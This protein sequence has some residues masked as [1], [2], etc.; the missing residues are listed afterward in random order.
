MRIGIDLDGV[1]FDTERAFRVHAELYDLLTL[2]TNNMK[3]RKSLRLQNRYNWNSQELEEF[4][5]I[6]H[7][8]IVREANYMSGVKEVLKMLKEEGHTLIVI[9]ARGGWNKIMIDITK[10]RMEEDGIIDFIDKFYF[11]TENKDEVCIKENIDLMIDDSVS[12]CKMVS[13]NK[14]KT[15]Y[16]QAEGLYEMEDNEYL[17]TLYNWGEVYRYIKEMER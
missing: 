14:I 17:T 12:K 10:E 4:L 6:Y 5:Q 13:E 3:D 2:K 11:I 8:K 7:E 9:T 15:I 16:F 1:I